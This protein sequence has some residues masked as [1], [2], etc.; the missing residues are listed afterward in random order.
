MKNH[1]LK[2]A[3]LISVMTIITKPLGFIREATI[4]SLFGASSQTDAFFL[5][6]NMPG[7]LFPAVCMSLSTSFLTI[8]VNK[9][10]KSGEKEGD[11]FGNSAI[12]FNL[13][14][15]AILSLL[16]FIF[17]PILVNVFAPGFDEQ[18]IILAIKL[19]R[20][21]MAAFTLLMLQYML[22]AILNGKGFYIGNQIAGVLYNLTIIITTIALGNRFGIIGLTL[23]FILGYIVQSIVLIIISKKKFKFIFPKK[24]IN[25]DTKYMFKTAIPILIGNSVIQLNNIVDKRIASKLLEG[26]VSA[27]SYSNTLNSF[28][29]SIIITSLSTVLYPTM[30]NYIANDDVRGL[31]NSVSSSIT[32]LTL[33]LMPISI[34]TSIYSEIIVNIAY[35]RGN[36]D[37]QAIILTASVLK[38]YALSFLFVGIREVLTKLF[39]AYGDTKVPMVNGLISVGLNILFSIVLSKHMGISGIA[40]GTTIALFISIILLIISVKRRIP[41]I[42]ILGYINNYYKIII[43][44]VFLLISSILLKHLTF[45]M[46]ELYRFSLVTT[47]G[48]FIYIS[49][50]YVLKCDELITMINFIKQKLKI[51]S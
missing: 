47:V 18:T 41:Q 27:L 7:L 48:F 4:A 29:I 28:V 23:T 15:A 34:I 40:L 38:F 9:M 20:I 11:M 25:T 17:S 32:I 51:K 39:Y 3:L 43:A 30:S 49:A 8:Y 35:G 36:F 2:S 12:I 45:G 14:I 6:Q 13:I 50:L 33:S 44:S 1:I 37:I 26:S 42:S 46:G 5:A 31:T 24:I 21:V 22:N 19:T 16:A 10:V